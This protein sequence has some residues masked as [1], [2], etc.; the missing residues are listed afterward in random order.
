MVFN[1]VRDAYAKAEGR[2]YLFYFLLRGMYNVVRAEDAEEILQSTK[3]ITK[4]VIYE[5]LEPFLGEGLLIS[6]GKY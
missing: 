6:T 5:L 4:N 3:L 1:Y 2:S